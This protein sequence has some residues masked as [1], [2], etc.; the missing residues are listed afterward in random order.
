[1]RAIG[2]CKTSSHQL[3]ASVRTNVFMKVH[4]KLPRII[5]RQK[6]A[7]ELWLTRINTWEK[8]SL[9]KSHCLN[10]AKFTLSKLWEAM[11]DF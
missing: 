1:M 7:T 6:V 4:L 2:D 5:T 3:Q 10:E 11:E 9:W 8:C